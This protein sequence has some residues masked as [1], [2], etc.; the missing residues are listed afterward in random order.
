MDKRSIL[1]LV[2]FGCFVLSSLLLA[3]FAS[4]T[5]ATVARQ[6]AGPTAVQD[7]INCNSLAPPVVGFETSRG[8]SAADVIDFL[9]DLELDGFGVGTVDMTT[10]PI[11]NCVDVLVVR[12]LAGNLALTSPYTAAEG[13]A[14]QTWVAQGHGLLVAGEWGTLKEETEALFQAF[15]YS[16]IG[17]DAA[18][19]TDP[20]DNDPTAPGFVG[21]GWVYFQADNFAAHP[22]FD[23]ANTLELLLSGWLAASP[24]T[25]VTTDTD[26]SPPSVPV[27][28][29]GNEGSG[30]VLFSADSNWFAI[31]NEGY[32]RE[33]NAQIARQSISWLNNCK[34]LSLVKTAVPNP[35]QPGG[36]ITYTLTTT[37]FEPTT[38]TN[39]TISDQIPAGT[40]FSSASAPFTGP[41]AAGVV[42]WPV[43]TLV[44]GAAATVTLVVAVAADAA[45][46]TTIVN[47]ANV[48]SS[49]GAT[50]S[51]TAVVTVA[52]ADPPVVTSSTT[53]LPIIMVD[54]CVETD[55]YADVVLA[56]DT[57][58][59]MDGTT[60]P[61][62]P[63]K[64]AAARAAATEFLNLLTFPG[65]QA[66][67]V[68]F[69]GTAV[70]QHPLSS[71]RASLIASLQGDV[72]GGT[73]LD[74]A[75]AEAR[76]ELTSVRHLPNNSP[77]LILLTDGRP[78]GTDD[79]AVLAQAT[80]TK[81]AGIII[82]TIGLGNDVNGPLLQDIA[83][84]AAHYYPAPSTA[85]LSQIY[86]DIGGTL[87]CP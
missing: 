49:Q 7:P 15:G 10:G 16:Q 54:F 45:D 26:A 40:T 8:Q 21:D 32:V 23:G 75:L 41:T 19:V 14:L 87:G 2:S 83:T 39:V 66:A 12:G 9:T 65:D 30:C 76:K 77:V 53:M 4:T 42:T 31:Y 78:D 62:G 82:Y 63:T 69:S 59:S 1:R 28:A 38:Q 25:I 55:R 84:T 81:A 80:T 86:Q 35:V 33:D 52:A 44:P 61:G 56:L 47:T 85:D 27:L 72:A 64:L 73:R 11:P 48:S 50:D 43:G 3:I 29:A 22:I 17:G 67:I 58:G 24:D 57:S 5:F 36:L 51:A 74:L 46:E 68:L 6:A 20:T 37:N 60:E 18:Y 34:F 71:D 13:A 70:L 79:A